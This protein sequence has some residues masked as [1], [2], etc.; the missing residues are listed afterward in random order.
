MLL[1]LLHLLIIMLLVS[2]F[3][4]SC[5]Q[6]TKDD[7]SYS[8]FLDDYSQV[9]NEKDASGEKVLRFVSPRLRSQGYNKILIEPIQ[10]Y[11]DPRADNKVTVEVLEQIRAYID[12]AMRLE[13]GQIVEIVNKPGTEVARMRVA[14]TGVG[15]DVEG[16]KPHQFIPVALVLTGARAAAGAHP[17]QA[18]LFLEAELTDSINGERLAV[19]IRGGKGERLEKMRKSGSVVTLESVKPLLDDWA[20]AYA[21][22]LADTVK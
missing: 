8:G 19:A 18:S 17:E 20:K 2:L 12:E 10:Y 21:K 7:A 9:K 4:S 3:I 16:L 13:I 22:F 14:L 6:K 11:P 1:R 15:A 5:A